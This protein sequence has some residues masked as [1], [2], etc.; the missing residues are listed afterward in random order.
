[1]AIEQINNI[2]G[3]L[4]RHRYISKQALASHVDDFIQRQGQ[5]FTGRCSARD[6]ILDVIAQHLYHSVSLVNLI[7]KK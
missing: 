7:H 1:M 5:L 3:T 6:K 4:I 2:A